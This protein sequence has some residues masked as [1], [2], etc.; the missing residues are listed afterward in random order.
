MHFPTFEATVLVSDF[1]GG[2]P[3]AKERLKNL[4]TSEAE[5]SWAFRSGMGS[6]PLVTGRRLV[7]FGVILPFFTGLVVL[8]GWIFG[9]PSL[10][11]IGPGFTAMQPNTAVGLLLAALSLVLLLRE[12]TPRLVAGKALAA[13]VFALGLLT[14]AQYVFG[15]DFRTDTL[16]ISPPASE[17]AKPFPLRMSPFTAFCFLSTGVGLLL[18]TA[19]TR[20]TTALSEVAVLAAML[21][22]LLGLMGHAYGAT[23]FY[24]IGNYSSMAVHT[25]LAFLALGCGI[26]AARPERGLGS[27]FTRGTSGSLLARRL[28]PAAIVLPLVLG[29]LR[30]KAEQAGYVELP[31][32]TALLVT[33]L[34]VTFIAL[35]WRTAVSLDRGD[36]ARQETGNALRESEAAKA[37]ILDSALDC[38][39]AMDREGCVI[40]WNPAAE[41]TFGYPRAEAMGKRLA[42]LIIPARYHEAHWR[43]LARFLESGAGP[44]LGKRVEMPAV[45]ANRSE[46]PVELSIVVSRADRLFFTAYLRDITERQ[47]AERALRESNER[48]HSLFNSID[49]GFCIIEVLFDERQTPVDYRFLEVNP[50]FERHTGLVDAVGKRMRE[51][52]P[53]HDPH[54]FETYGKVALTGEATRIEDYSVTMQ[55]WFDVHASRVDR[56]EERKVAVLFTNITDRKRAEAAT[57]R[58]AAIVESSQDAIISKDLNGIITT[59]NAGAERLLGYSAEEA[60]GQPVM[61]LIPRGR[62]DEEVRILDGIRRGETFNNFETVRRHHDGALI[63]VSLTISP[64]RDAAGRVAGVSKIMRD[65]TGQKR[66]ER[67]LAEK[68]RLLD[69]SND[70]IIARNLDGNIT[71]WNR[72]AEK[73]YG[74]RADE[75]MGRHMHTLLQ[76]V[77][78]KPMAE[79]LDELYRE[80]S[81]AAEVVQ[82]ARDG[83]RIPLLCRWALDEEE[84]S[85]LTSY[86]DITE[87]VQAQRE[88]SEKARLLDLTNDAVVVRDTADHITFWNLGAEKLFGWTREEALGKK[89]HALLE[90]EFPMPMEEIKAELQR[91]GKF[92]GEVVQFA[93]DGRSIPSLC[94]WVLD[95]ETN[96]I[97]TSYTDMTALR[98]AEEAL[99]A[100]EKQAQAD[101]QRHADSLELTVA[102]RTAKLREIIG[103]L[104]AFSFSL[105]HDMRAPLRAIQNFSKFALEDCGEKGAPF[106]SKVINAAS[107]L[108]RMIEE[109]LSFTKIAHQEIRLES[110]DVNCLVQD[111]IAERPEL[112]PPHAEIIVETPLQSMRGHEASLTQCLTNL[113]ANAVKFV[114]RDVKPRVIVSSESRGEGVRLWIEDNGI[115]IEPSAQTKLFE[116]FY[117]INSDRDY[118][119]TG[120]GLAIVRKAAERM[121]G[122]VGVE[123]ELGRGSRFWLELP[124]A[125]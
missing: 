44:L 9:W 62:V 93:R 123:S 25:A 80:K 16:L 29:W 71:V 48:Y 78:P 101:L 122:T 88:L 4:K 108:D 10:T 49:E 31:I 2:G 33:A 6:S 82:T 38:I 77:L 20:R 55:R 109:V 91:H 102:E 118:D 14:T 125:D 104:E 43:G 59:W 7:H 35:I 52:I 99:R 120:L 116:M 76:T 47:R 105:S 1:H 117:R 65:I 89:L 21:T 115:G 95:R 60:V 106:L 51:L 34:M 66:S 103:E 97:L 58:L 70:A 26:L 72:G 73:Y 30:V 92:A 17:L 18:R 61:M 8:G 50:A 3:E 94:R 90:T 54:W 86:T 53:N 45:N 19:R 27:L 23:A 79:I 32:G 96:S 124:K 56:P 74:W 28:L 11:T 40:E 57:Q 111:I 121:G 39:I 75:V 107:R 83:R 13:L 114:A 64:I 112:Q 69:L 46:F 67:E 85:I 12:T 22:A 119:G 36:L 5:S 87:R 100:A 41:K 24:R 63:D 110:L 84:G 42:D 15:A 81:F 98:R 37:A 68:A 113:L